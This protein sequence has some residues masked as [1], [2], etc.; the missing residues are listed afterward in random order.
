MEETW[1]VSEIWKN[2]SKDT[3]IF[4]TEFNGMS[5]QVKDKKY[6]RH[7]CMG[8]KRLRH[9]AIWI[10]RPFELQ[11]KYARDIVKVVDKVKNP[12]KILVLGLG[13]GCIP[14]YLYRT[15]PE[16][17]IDVVDIVPELK[18]ISY[19]YFFMPENPRLNVELRLFSVPLERKAWFSGLKKLKK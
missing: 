2:V 8:G 19:K 14:T 18:D 6:V 7:L 5:I 10:S 12:K 13:G 11:M 16:T 17:H 15:L 1:E 9:T 4:E 3:I